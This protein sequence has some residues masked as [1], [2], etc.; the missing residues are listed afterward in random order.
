MAISGSIGKRG[1][2]PYRD[3]VWRSYDSR[4]RTL[5]FRAVYFG[6]LRFRVD[7]IDCGPIY[8][9]VIAQYSEAGCGAFQT[10]GCWPICTVTLLASARHWRTG[11]AAQNAGLGFDVWGRDR[12]V[13][14]RQAPSD[15]RV[16]D[17]T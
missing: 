16:R 10:P 6:Y 2:E 9:C 5:A 7:L 11:L 15:V 1:S 3:D 14:M 13:R 17:F 8:L 4:K 12:A